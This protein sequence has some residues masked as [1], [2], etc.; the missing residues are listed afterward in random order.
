MQLS[1]GEGGGGEGGGE[2][3]SGEGE[4]G[5]EVAFGLQSNGVT[6]LPE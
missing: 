1:G 5:G 6:Q 3:S 2:G 4:G